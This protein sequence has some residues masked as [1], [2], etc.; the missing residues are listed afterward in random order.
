MCEFLEEIRSFFS[1]CKKFPKLVGILMT[2][3]IHGVAI[4][5]SD[6]RGSTGISDPVVCK[7][8]WQPDYSPSLEAALDLGR[9]GSTCSSLR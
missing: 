5:R 3:S 8:F 1:P 2:V 6:V 4:L 9:R 7:E